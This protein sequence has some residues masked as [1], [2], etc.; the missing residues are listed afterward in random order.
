MGYEKF[1]QNV[2]LFGMLSWVRK[3]LLSTWALEVWVPVVTV[4]R[5]RVSQKAGSVICV[6]NLVTNAR[7]S[8]A[9]KDI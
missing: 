4:K 5:R 1:M 2:V 8:V 6:L 9:K 7:K 3:Y